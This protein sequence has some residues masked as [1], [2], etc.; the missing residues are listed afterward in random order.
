MPELDQGASARHP[1]QA[2]GA[3]Q[4]PESR[5]EPG[6]SHV[7]DPGYVSRAARG[8]FHSGY[9]ASTCVPLFEYHPCQIICIIYP[10]AQPLGLDGRATVSLLGGRR[11]IRDRP[12]L[13]LKVDTQAQLGE[14]MPG[15]WSGTRDFI[16]SYK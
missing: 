1:A 15:C 4:C 8:T 2:S 3:S 7:R 9:S 5:G 10:M 13:G 12:S 16:T 14:Q 6:A 11:T